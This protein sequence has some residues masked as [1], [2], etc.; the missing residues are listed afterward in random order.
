MAISRS[1]MNKQVSKA[2]GAKGGHKPKPVKYAEN[3]IKR[4][5]SIGVT[6]TR[7]PNYVARA[8]RPGG[9]AEGGS[10]GSAQAKA[11][12][13]QKPFVQ[14]GLADSRR[15]GHVPG[16]GKEVQARGLAAVVAAGRNRK[17]SG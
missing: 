4:A 11:Q 8:T 2:P 14:A 5:K 9:Y 16:R 15:A 12:S 13:N 6:G 3:I 10:V 17:R 7:G 1:N